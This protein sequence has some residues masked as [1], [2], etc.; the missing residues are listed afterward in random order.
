M[1]KDINASPSGC[2]MDGYVSLLCIVSFNMF[3]VPL[4]V[5]FAR[6]A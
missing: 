6:V 5:A 4:F 2:T 3:I 1:E